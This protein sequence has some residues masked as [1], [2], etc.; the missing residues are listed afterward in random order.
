MK[1]IMK[2]AAAALLVTGAIACGEHTDKPAD[3]TDQPVAV[4][5]DSAATTE[6]STT[7]APATDT[8]ATPAPPATDSSATT[9]TTETTS[10]TSTQQ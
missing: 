7:V 6:T 4:S 10:T 3:T 9:V 5:T 2:L 8:T 1:K